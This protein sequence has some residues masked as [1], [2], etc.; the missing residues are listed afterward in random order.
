VAYE[1]GS[2][3]LGIKNPF[4]IEGLI[5][6]IK[7]LIIFVLGV[8]CLLVVQNLVENGLKTE[9]WFTLSVGIFFVG[10]G[11]ASLGKGLFQMMRF[12]AGR[13]V[14]T[15]LA[16]N[17]SKS[18]RNANET[19]VAYT[20]QTLE[21]MLQGRKNLTF[22]EPVGWIARMIHTVFPNSLFLPY[23][24]RNLIQSIMEN[25]LLTL[26]AFACFIL[27]WF[28][29][30]TGL[31]TIN[32]TPLLDW[33]AVIMT[34]YLFVIWWKIH[35]PLSRNLQLKTESKGTL[36]IIVSIVT[37]I[38]LPFLLAYI[39]HHFIT[40]P[41]VPFPVGKYLLLLLFC[42]ALTTALVTLLI[43]N[44]IK[45][46]R[47]VTEVSEL[48]DNW[49]ESVHPQELFIHFETIIMANRRFQEVPNR[50]Y[51]EFDPSL[52]EEGSD[53]KGHFS[54]EAIQETQPVSKSSESPLF[55]ILRIVTTVIGHTLIVISF[56]LLFIN[57]EDFAKTAN[58]LKRNFEFQYL[59]NEFEIIFMIMIIW[60]FGKSLANFAHAFWAE[61]RFESLM[62]FFQCQ[63]TYSE[64]KLSTGTSI[65][66]ST[67]SEN[68]VVRSSITPWLLSCTIIS[69]CF[70]ESGKRNLEFSRH[71]MEMHSAHK[72][73][74]T[75]LN[76][77]LDFIRSRSTIAGIN[78]EEDLDSAYNIHQMNKKTRTD[79]INHKKNTGQ[80]ELDQERID[81]TTGNNSDE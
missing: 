52:I 22:T 51:R 72:E 46:T 81:E 7:G 5:R 57:I 10:S 47:P 39:H 14:P 12:F 19:G 16:K 24:Y 60:L 17:L 21:Q 33:L 69:I 58:L 40:F 65:Y 42:V 9:G 41:E 6:S 73:H 20:A 80:I 67:R 23:P 11:L 78:S 34:F 75:I 48:R 30:A 68:I 2:I 15:S 76:E 79:Y 62:V 53:D 4:K 49:Q 18:E 64:S 44:R 3:D 71:I 37:S 59:I 27:A 38:F 56:V 74:N 25:T 45:A 61:M 1:Y 35:T 63:G 77:L 43:H 70:A 13:G 32:N 54:G 55:D 50:V 66:D 26:L 31:T 29:G 28:S 8:Y 36:Y